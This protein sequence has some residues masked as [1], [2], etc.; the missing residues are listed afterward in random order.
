MDVFRPFHSLVSGVEG[1]LFDALISTGF[2]Q[3]SATLAR[4][5]GRSQAQ[6]WRVMNRLEERCIVDCMPDEGGNWFSIPRGSVFGTLMTR[7]HDLP[8]DLVNV[9]VRH[10]ESWKRT[11]RSVFLAPS[12]W[13]HTFGHDTL[14]VVVA[15]DIDAV[16]DDAARLERE[17]NS[18]VCRGIQ[19]LCTTSNALIVQ[20]REKGLLWAHARLRPVPISGESLEAVLLHPGGA[21]GKL[22]AGQ[23]EPGPVR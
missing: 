13:A 3:T 6:V 22:L 11:P 10:I 2:S 16:T 14:V 1:D 8:S 21:P 9:A 20:L 12:E 19:V 5:T 17:L 18:A 15:E 7:F 23:N 4:L